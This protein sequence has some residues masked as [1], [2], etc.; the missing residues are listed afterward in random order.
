MRCL[1]PKFK[2]SMP[3][4][5]NPFKATLRGPAGDIRQEKA[6]RYAQIEKEEKSVFIDA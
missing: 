4:L 6:T 3:Y 1:L 5:T 2:T